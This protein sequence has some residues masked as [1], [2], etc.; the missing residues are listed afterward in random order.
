MEE[1]S[2][3]SDQIQC[4][5]CAHGN[6][7]ENLFCIHCGKRVA[8]KKNNKVSKRQCVLFGGVVLVL[9]ITVGFCIT[10][11]SESPS[12]GKVNDEA[13]PRE[14]FSKKVDRMKKLYEG[15]Y[16][17]NLF[18]GEAGK[19]NLNRL[20]AQILDEL[21]TERILLHE[22]RKAGYTSAPREQIERE[23]EEIKKKNGISDG[24]IET[25]MG[26]TIDDFKSQLGKEW[27]I[28][29]FVE[30]TVLKGKREDGNAIFSQWFAKA[31]KDAKVEILEKLDPVPAATPSCC[32]TGS[33]GCAGGGKAQPLDPKIE[34]EA[35]TKGLEYYEKKTK[36]K[37][38]DARV[39]N[40]G[41][42]IQVDVM[43]GEKV[44]ISL[45]YR[46]GEVEEI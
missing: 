45:T 21:V 42:H 7:A 44:V 38:A 2:K 17:E 27:V 31:K 1:L 34:Q 14:E 18:Q 9:A 3:Q 28:S 10:G 23:L 19:N 41:C 40:F 12:V 30:K 33:G 16:G 36:K 20:K 46:Q 25:M 32:S 22:A 11:F 37:G 15:R 5:F 43:E 24:Q 26:G 39:T 29:E 35:R 4:P 6:E 13:I 8:V